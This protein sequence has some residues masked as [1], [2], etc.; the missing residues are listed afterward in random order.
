MKKLIGILA[1]AVIIGSTAYAEVDQK[2]DNEVNQ[3]KIEKQEAEAE[4]EKEVREVELK[5]I[6]NIKIKDVMYYAAG[7]INCP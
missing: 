4:V 5:E 7:D 6:E 3:T 1:F 2:L